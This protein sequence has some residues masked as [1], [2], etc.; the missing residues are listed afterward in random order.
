MAR[1]QRRDLSVF[2]SSCHLPTCL[3]NT[4]E[5]SHCLFDC[6]TSSSEYQ[7]LY[8]WFD[9]TGKRTQ[10]YSFRSRRSIHSTTDRLTVMVRVRYVGMLFELKI[11]DFS[12]IA[13]AFCMQRQNTA[14]ADAK[15]VNWD[16][17][18]IGWWFQSQLKLRV[19]YSK[20]GSTVRYV[21][22]VRYAS[23]FAKKYCT[24]EPYVFFVMVRVRCVG[25]IR[26]KNWTEVR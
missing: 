11:P 2:E 17:W 19:V 24:L 9:P 18:F 20:D 1:R 14:E 10:V 13:P 23:N 22:T 5:A 26:F 12:H 4:A 25:T 3:P 6:S 15:C 8:L 7:F 21:T 16:R